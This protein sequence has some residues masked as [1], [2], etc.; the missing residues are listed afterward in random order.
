MKKYLTTLLTEKGHTT[1]EV[2]TIP[3]NYGIT[4][5]MLFDFIDNNGTVEVKNKIYNTAVQI[6]FHNGFVLH[7]F[8]HLAQGMVKACGY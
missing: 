1:D 8:N 5:E 3:G 4:Y 6:D 2:I 7:Y